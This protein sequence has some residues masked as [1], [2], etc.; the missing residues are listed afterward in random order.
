[1][2]SFSYKIGL[3]LAIIGLLVR[4]KSAHILELSFTF[5]DTNFA[6]FTLPGNFI[7]WPEAEASCINWGGYLATIKSEQVDSLL[8]YTPEDIQI[9]FG[10]FLGL[11][12]ME[13]EAGTIASAFV[14]VDGSNSSYRKFGNTPGTDI[15]PSDQIQMTIMI[16]LGSGTRVGL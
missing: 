11:N 9:H 4:I 13:N 7:N 1:M 2:K 5:D 10:C 16:V 15:Y 8:Y 14:W 6:Y 3:F 12:D